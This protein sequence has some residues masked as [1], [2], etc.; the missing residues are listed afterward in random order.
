MA[1]AVLWRIL[2]GEASINSHV[3]ELGS[4]YFLKVD[5]SALAKLP[6]NCNLGE[7]LD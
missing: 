6:D 1:S 4:G 7:L 2:Y 3:S 5:L